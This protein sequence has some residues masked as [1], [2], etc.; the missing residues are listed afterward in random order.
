MVKKSIIFISCGIFKE[1]LEYI[2]REKGLDW[3]IVFQDAAL[4]VNFDKLKE[5]LVLSLEEASRKGME[6][7]VI[8]GY[9]HPVMQDL[10]DRYGAKRIPAAN[11]LEAMV[12]AEELRRLDSEAVTFFLSAGW[13]NNWENM[14]ALGKKDF[15]FEFKSMFDRYRRIIVFDTGVISVNEDKVKL[16]SD[17][18]GLPVERKIITL[19]HFFNLV[20]AIAI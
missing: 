4:H 13:A 5:K 10:L 6:I 2:V 15:G 14:F 11:C 3:E 18:T 12:G 7:R 8:Y 16:F 1:E 20:N 9:C 19:D 17:F